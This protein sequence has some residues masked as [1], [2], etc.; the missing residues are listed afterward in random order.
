MDAA[1]DG[2][3]NEAGLVLD[4]LQGG[5]RDPLAF[6]DFFDTPD[7]SHNPLRDKAVA[8]DDIFRVA[9]R[10]GTSGDPAVDPL[11][12][13]PKA[14]YHPAYD[15]G[16]QVGGGVGWVGELEPD[17][18]GAGRKVPSGEGSNQADRLADRGHHA[19]AGAGIGG[20]AEPLD[21]TSDPAR[22]RHARPPCPAR[23]ALPGRC[24]AC[25]AGG[26]AEAAG[27][28]RPCGRESR[29]RFVITPFRSVIT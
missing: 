18:A 25:A 11:S 9:E 24:A 27:R 4:P 21:E 8:L 6:W 20:G 13:P 26:Q 29:F 28:I 10:F 14:G 12:K 15:R 17:R 3:S 1:G 2:A 5:L 7:T 23:S 16:G 19:P 22:C